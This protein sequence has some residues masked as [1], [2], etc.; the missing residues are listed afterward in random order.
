[1]GNEERERSLVALED[2]F[3]RKGEMPATARKLA[4]AMLGDDGAAGEVTGLLESWRAR[5]RAQ[6]AAP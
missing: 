5:F 2:Y 1:M 6:P 3:V 4:E